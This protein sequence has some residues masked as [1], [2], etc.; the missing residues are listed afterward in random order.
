VAFPGRYPITLGVDT[1][2]DVIRRAGGFTAAANRGGARL[3]RA[4]DPVAPG[5]HA[6][7]G[8]PAAGGTPAA[9]GTGGLPSP[10]GVHEPQRSTWFNEP[11]FAELPRTMRERELLR[12]SAGGRELHVDW[13]EEPFAGATRLADGDAI[14]VPRA[15]GT[16]RVDGRVR[17][18]GL[19]P[20]APERAIEDY[21]DLAGGYDKNADRGRLLVQRAGRPALEYADGAGPIGDGDAIWVPEKTPRSAWAITREVITM[22]AAVASII[23]FAHEVSQ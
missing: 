3:F 14:H 12:L 23:F 21:V 16:V 20:F 10:G 19:V 5:S 13:Q 8:S 7:P 2:D 1:V 9:A 11:A 22:A 18:P 15:A 4:A 17:A 6:V